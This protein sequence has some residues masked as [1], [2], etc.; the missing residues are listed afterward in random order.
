MLDKNEQI[1]GDQGYLGDDPEG[2][3]TQDGVGFNWN[4]EVRIKEKKRVDARIETVN[5]NWKQFGCMKTKPFRHSAA[6]HQTF[7]FAIAVCSQIAIELGE[8]EVYPTYAG[9][10]NK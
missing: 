5:S 2:F 3:V 1:D 9:T 6:Q 4:T 8:L 7:F 10:N